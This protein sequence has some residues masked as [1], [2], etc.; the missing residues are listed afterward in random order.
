MKNKLILP[1]LAAII[2]I[3]SINA[4]AE[5]QNNSQNNENV[6]NETIFQTIDKEKLL[7]DIADLFEDSASLNKNQKIELASNILKQSNNNAFIKNL[8]REHNDSLESQII[9]F[10]TSFNFVYL[11]NPY[12]FSAKFHEFYGTHEHEENKSERYYYE[13]TFIDELNKVSNLLKN[14]NI[15]L[16]KFDYNELLK[17]KDIDNYETKSLILSFN[18]NLPFYLKFKENSNPI[19]FFGENNELSI[20][21][22]DDD[23]FKY[24]K[25]FNDQ[26]MEPESLD[27][28]VVID[29]K[30]FIF[31]SDIGTRFRGYYKK[32]NT[33]Y[34]TS[35]QDTRL[36][37]GNPTNGS[38]MNLV[39]SVDMTI[40][41]D[42][43]NVT[44][45]IPKKLTNADIII[46]NESEVPVTINYKN[47]E[48][49]K[50]SNVSESVSFSFGNNQLIIKGPF[51]IHN[52]EGKTINPKDIEKKIS[53]IS[54]K[55]DGEE[56][57]KYFENAGAD[58]TINEQFI[59]IALLSNKN[60]YQPKIINDVLKISYEQASDL[61]SSLKE[62]KDVDYN[63][64]LGVLKQKMSA[65]DFNKIFEIESKNLN[66]Q[67]QDKLYKPN[68]YPSP[69]DP[70]D[71][72]FCELE[73]NYVFVNYAESEKYYNQ[74]K[75]KELKVYSETTAPDSYIND[76]RFNKN[77]CKEWVDCQ[78][79]IDHIKLFEKN[80]D[81]GREKGVYTVIPKKM[82][83]NDTVCE[84]EQDAGKYIR[85]GASYCFEL[86]KNKDDII[87][88]DYKVI[89]IYKED[90]TYIYK[91]EKNN[92][93]EVIYQRS[94]QSSINK[95]SKYS[96]KTCTTKY[97]YGYPEERKIP[98]FEIL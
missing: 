66:V 86:N 30:N 19:D 12:E 52:K 45:V 78:Y 49:L 64:V 56:Y 59:N 61:I 41:K 71:Y 20:L 51:V 38:T 63:L 50:I 58:L 21:N 76:V 57:N 85:S 11:G 9:S 36:G 98:T 72:S 17:N 96:K 5:I 89:E 79:S 16:A 32:D 67:S 81:N 75:N 31:V 22:Y 23:Y 95:V 70:E 93:N 54:S 74:F 88:A 92:T 44:I 84:K 87:M 94:R 39:G 6:I 2:S 34:Y 77:D 42:I 18:Y 14:N 25:L 68:S 43:N 29:G 3:N 28:S 24:R 65:D 10:L 55:I 35:Y 47:N 7:L 97:S 37:T 82:G 90:G 91:I 53:L 1:L 48:A 46:S 8:I 33:I 62:I 40:N 15:K 4:L 80:L 26:N 27:K 69:I 73:K 13:Q 83:N 60:K